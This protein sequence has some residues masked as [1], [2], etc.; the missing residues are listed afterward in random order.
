M[1]VSLHK[2][3]SLV[4]SGGIIAVL[5]ISHVVSAQDN[6]TPIVVQ[7]ASPTP[8]PVIGSSA[9]ATPLPTPTETP[10]GP[11]QVTIA[12]GQGN[13][14]VRR[15]ADPESDILGIIAPGQSFAVSGRYYRWI[16]LR[17][18]NSPNG[19]GYV[20]DELVQLVG[21]TTLIPDLTLVDT[22][23]VDT[24]AVGAIDL[25]PVIPGMDA[26][27]TAQTRII[28]APVGVD[29]NAT[30]S[31]TN[32]NPDGAVRLPTYTPVPNI[33]D[34]L[35]A[36]NPEPTA[37]IVPIDIINIRE[38]ASNLPPI[39]PIAFLGGLGT[40]GFFISLMRKS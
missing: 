12:E 32:L 4:I 21:D 39:V 16:Q 29:P 40:L 19:L 20:Y 17:F 24:V 28:I 25:T 7:L 2:L 26:T 33:G 22:A 14:N 31:E 23:V 37:T 13:V 1:R 30:L 10:L 15:E 3:C 34:L 38:T 8:L 36:A 35:S 18:P 27:T 5:S 11:V 9:S 6:P